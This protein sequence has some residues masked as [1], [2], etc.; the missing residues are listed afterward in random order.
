MPESR[1]LFL[2]RW[3]RSP[4]KM[5]YL[6]LLRAGSTYTEKS[7]AVWMEIYARQARPPT[8]TNPVS[9]AWKNGNREKAAFVHL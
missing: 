2:L 7:E 4:G 5:F 1:A 3:N 6:Q 9:V 8:E